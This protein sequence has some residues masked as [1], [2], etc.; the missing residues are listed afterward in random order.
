MPDTCRKLLER[1]SKQNAPHKTSVDGELAPDANEEYLLYQIL[2]GSWPL[3]ANERSE[4]DNGVY[5]QRI[6]EYMAKAIKEAKANS[7]WIQPNPEW[8]QAV[9]DFVAKLLARDRR[10]AFLRA[11]KPSG[12]LCSAR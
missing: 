11:F 12:A 6:Q 7:S 1:V 9:N 2:L 8:D 3:D 4:A 5:V 10:N